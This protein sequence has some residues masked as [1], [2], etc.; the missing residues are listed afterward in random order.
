MA[1]A[2]AIK[3][4]LKKLQKVINF[5]ATFTFGKF[6]LVKKSRIDDI[7][8]CVYATLPDT[9]KK[10]L[11]TKNDVQRY[12]SV[13]CY[14]LLSKLLAK[15]FFLDKSMCIVNISEVNK[16]IGSVILSIERDINNIEQ[17]FSE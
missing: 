5:D 6:K 10:M 1:E 14:G 15:T 9:Y 4:Y 2:D 8:C 7:M 11:K 3:E 17:L 13:I 12:S 16:L